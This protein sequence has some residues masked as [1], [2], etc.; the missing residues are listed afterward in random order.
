M[1]MSASLR[2]L[3]IHARQL[4]ADDRFGVRQPAL[5]PGDVEKDAAVRAPPPLANFA[6][7]AARDVVAGQELRRPARALVALG[8]APAFF[9]VVGGLAA[10]VLRNGVEEESGGLPC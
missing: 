7:D 6:H 2:K 10:V 3:V 5:D 9:L 1:S 4:L 8:V